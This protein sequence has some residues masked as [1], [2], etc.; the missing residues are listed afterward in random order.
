MAKKSKMESL[1]EGMLGCCRV[2][3]I[4]TIDER[5]QM[6]LPKEVRKN[7]GIQAGDKMAIVVVESGQ[8]RG[9]IVMLRV[10]QLAG[11]VKQALGPMLSEIIT[12]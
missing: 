4:V 5:G 12:P 9:C 7:A 3:S 1:H 10:D 8:S 6:V 11:L 2:E